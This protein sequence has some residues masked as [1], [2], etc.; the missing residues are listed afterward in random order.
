M[1]VGLILGIPHLIEGF[2]ETLMNGAATLPGVRQVDI[3]ICQPVGDDVVDVA[4]VCTFSLVK[5][6]PS[7]RDDDEIIVVGDVA[8]RTLTAEGPDLCQSRTLKTRFGEPWLCVG[9][10][11]ASASHQ[12]LTIS[13][14][15]EACRKGWSWEPAK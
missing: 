6:R 11:A 7:K 10:K 5:F 1:L 9:Q 14:P 13:N 4:P 15:P 8:L 3:Q 12:A 2:F